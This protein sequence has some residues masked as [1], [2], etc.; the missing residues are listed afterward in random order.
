MEK[1][2]G[3]FSLLQTAHW[4]GRTFHLALDRRTGQMVHLVEEPAGAS[5]PPDEQPTLPQLSL[6]EARGETRW[7]I[8]AV[9][10][11]ETAEDLHLR[12]ALNGQEIGAILLA[13]V[14][15][16][17]ALTSIKPPVVPGYIDPACIKRTPSGQ[18]KLDYLVLA[19]TVGASAATA[20][21]NASIHSFGVFLFWLVSGRDL[22][23]EEAQ[24][25]LGQGL[26]PSIQFMVM[27]YLGN[28]Y[29]RLADVRATVQKAVRENIFASI[30]LDGSES[31]GQPVTVVHVGETAVVPVEVQ[32]TG[33][34]A[35]APRL[36][37]RVSG[38]RRMWPVFAVVLVLA[39]FALPRL[40][41]GGSNATVMPPAAQ[42]EAPKQTSLPEPAP[43]P[44]EVLVG[45]QAL[46]P[47]LE[48]G[49]TERVRPT[50]PPA[51]ATPPPD[52][53]DDPEPVYTPPPPLP[54]P[55]CEPGVTKSFGPNRYFYVD[56]HLI[57]TAHVIGSGV[58]FISSNAVGAVADIS[59]AR[60]DTSD[61]RTVDG[62]L[63]IALRQ[64]SMNKFHLSVELVD[65][66]TVRLKHL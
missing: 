29:S 62:R 61:Y 52:D 51:P 53:T 19:H 60:L 59:V 56:G 41:S 20:Q 1:V 49:Y 30:R 31:A 50:S 39:G 24:T 65:A 44:Q 7:F 4:A 12:G 34:G 8:A 25:D 11:G 18:W 27:R 32:V 47:R 37:R 26:P 22:R 42:P 16:L 55:Y 17:I 45:A 46:P 54:G 13:V 36:K 66:T 43:P 3:Q 23:Q 57:C 2:F 10:E 5:G 40:F 33:T 14:D 28:T 21:A 38:K 9:T 15:A 58:L 64:S 6:L 63:W 48:L 35:P